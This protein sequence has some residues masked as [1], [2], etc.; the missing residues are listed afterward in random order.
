MN[1]D[2]RGIRF[3]TSTSSFG[4]DPFDPNSGQRFLAKL[5][6]LAGSERS[7]TLSSYFEYDEELLSA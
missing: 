3:D 7:I 1:L 4:I 6:R 5:L 2:R